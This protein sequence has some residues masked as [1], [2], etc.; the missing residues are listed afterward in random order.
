MPTTWRISQFA[1]NR[2]PTKDDK[3]VYIAGAFDLFHVG[4][5][6]TLK[7]ARELGTFLYVGVHDDESVN[8]QVNDFHRAVTLALSHGLKL[9]VCVCQLG[10]N[11]PIMNLHERVLNVLSCR[12]VDEVILG[13]PLI[14]SQDLLRTLNISVVALGGNLDEV[15]EV[16]INSCP[17]PPSP[18]L[19][20]T[21]HH[22]HHHHHGHTVPQSDQTLQYASAREAGILEEISVSR[23]LKTSDVV[24]RIVRNR[25]KYENRNSSRE[26]KERAYIESRQFVQ[27]I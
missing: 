26:V 17:L 14:V 9:C 20:P 12:W 7:K 15:P 8:K 3:V 18:S 5:I 16:C 22:R 4:H 21:H 23:T 13:A 25:M 27:E 6:E 24:E 11:Y 10:R 19:S 2:P 1:N